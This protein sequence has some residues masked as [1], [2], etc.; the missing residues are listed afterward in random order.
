MLINIYILYVLLLIILI[1][2]HCGEWWL[3]IVTQNI[4]I[5]CIMY[6]DHLYSQY[7]CGIYSSYMQC[8]MIKYSPF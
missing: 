8:Y 3:M 4:C 7:L 5:V 1:N 2:T 6:I